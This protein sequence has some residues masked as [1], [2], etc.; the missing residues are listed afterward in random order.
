MPVPVPVPV[1]GRPRSHTSVSGPNKAADAAV[2]LANVSLACGGA[3]GARTCLPLA[4]LTPTLVDA[5]WRDADTRIFDPR[6]VRNRRCSNCSAAD[7]SWGLQ[8]APGVKSCS[9]STERQEAFV[10]RLVSALGVANGGTFIEV[11]GHDGLHASNTVFTQLCRK[12]RGLMIEA[13]PSSFRFLRRRRA[14]VVAVRTALC[15]SAGS[16]EFV[17]RDA[18]YKGS[19]RSSAPQIELRSA[20]Y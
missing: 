9:R 15:A 1:Q 4:E 10:L 18:T 3:R 14:G 11:G 13:N 7:Q 5:W 20:N 2:H 6:D 17:T 19:D 12:W 16:V 8:V